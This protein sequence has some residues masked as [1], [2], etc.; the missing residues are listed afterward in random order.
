MM[1]ENLWLVYVYEGK[2]RHDNAPLYYRIW[3]VKLPVVISLVSIEY[4]N[5]QQPLKLGCIE[6]SA[7]LTAHVLRVRERGIKTRHL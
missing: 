7:L 3:V 4:Y 1:I 5:S 6:N 2:A